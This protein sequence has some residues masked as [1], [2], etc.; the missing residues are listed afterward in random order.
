LGRE[1]HFGGVMMWSDGI[2][3]ILTEPK[4][5]GSAWRIG[6]QGWASNRSYRKAAKIPEHTRVL[7]T[8]DPI[9]VYYPIAVFK[10]NITLK[11]S[12]NFVER[13]TY[14]SSS[15]EPSQ[16]LSCTQT[17]G[18]YLSLLFKYLGLLSAA[19]LRR[20]DLQPWRTFKCQPSRW[21]VLG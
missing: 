1:S 16:K 14:N 4:C 15:D 5:G 8:R 17:E 18:F 9:L 19:E 11:E 10:R 2:R 13:V 21:C 12:R 20:G 6:I 3:E 7:F